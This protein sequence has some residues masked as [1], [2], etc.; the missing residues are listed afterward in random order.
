MTPFWITGFEHG[1]ASIVAAG[2]GLTGAI[3]GAPTVQSSVKKTGSY[4][5]LINDA[6]ETLDITVPAVKI[7]V[8]S[9]DIRYSVFPNAKVYHCCT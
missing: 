7:S 4:A 9:F 3:A 8:A 1:L 2:G 5:L 6:S